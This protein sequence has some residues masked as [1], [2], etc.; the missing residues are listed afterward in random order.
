MNEHK[1]NGEIRHETVRLIDSEGEMLGVVTSREALEKAIQASLD[2]VE[3][4]P[5]ADPPVCK[6]MDYGKFKYQTQKKKAEAKKNQKIVTVKEVKVRPY[7]EENDYQVKKRNV[8]RFLADGDKVKISMRFRGREMSRK[9][10][11][12]RIFNRFK[13][14]F[15][16]DIKIEREPRMEGMQMIM[17]IAPKI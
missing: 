9:E 12:T 8:E 6:I 17:I 7:I 2:L 13:E 16:E 3:I 14:E 1:I 5:N 10:I 11:G 4:S 15:S